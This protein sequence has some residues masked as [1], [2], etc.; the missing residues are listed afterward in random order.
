V[1]NASAAVPIQISSNP[2]PSAL[3]V[4]TNVVIDLGFNI[5]LDPTTLTA[6]TVLCYQNGNWFQSDINL[7]NGGTV[8]QVAPRYQLQPNT[9]TTCQVS[10]SLQG[11][12]GVP[13]QGGGL[14]F[15]TGSGSDTVVPTI[16]TLSP[17][18]GLS[19]V[20]DN[21]NVRLVFSKPINPLTVN[22]STIQLSGDGA[23]PVPDSI[24]FSNNNQMV[25]V[26]PHAPLPDNT[27]MTLT[28]SGITDVAG[29]PAAPQTTQFTTGTGPDVI[30]PLVVWTNPL[31][32]NV[33]Q[34]PAGVPLNAV[35]QI[36]VNEPVDPGT[37]NSSTFSVLDAATNQS[38][39]GTYSVSADGLTITFVP[40]AALEVDH[41]F[42]VYSLNG[43]ITDL[44]G[45]GLSTAVSPVMGNFTF[46][47]GTAASTSGPQVAG[48]SPASGATGTPINARVV[49]GFNEPVDAT[50]LSGLTLTGPSGAVNTS[51]SISNGNQTIG[52]IPTL[53]LAAG[54]Q[55]TVNIAGVQD[56][57]GN[58]LSAPVTSSFT[59][60]TSAD[61]TLPTVAS[62]SPSS[63][64]TGVSTTATVQVQF[65]KAIDPL[66]V[67]P[68][69]FYI[70]PSG[71][72]DDLSL[73]QWPDGDSHSQR[74][75]GLTHSLRSSAHQWYHRHGGPESGEWRFILLHDGPGHD[76]SG[77]CNWRY[78]SSQCRHRHD[79]RH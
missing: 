69:T 30:A 63:S 33:Y 59:T 24:S 72:R 20:G 26:V 48:V 61:L 49:V 21:A 6:T 43:G 13:F 31:E 7:V 68:T 22:A 37:V 65:S 27:Q 62:S 42:S 17:P 34:A 54:T 15:T 25:F 3:N 39:S 11:L 52:L 18:S 47:T 10:A 71:G 35:V 16:M 70:Y 28:I 55:Y 57:S 45:N 19:N 46:T 75:A 67:L 14:G 36:Q 4:P 8:I 41:P 78:N 44:A 64:A 29:N 60:G 58:V 56:F 32:T 53:P 66:T 50:K 73:G 40:A 2:A 23:T 38:V 76:H 74:T 12:N 9:Y 5:P 1:P 77:T 79:R 51:P